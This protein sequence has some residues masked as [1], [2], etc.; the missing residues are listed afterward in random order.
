[1]LT[2]AIFENINF[3]K[4]IVM[5]KTDG[6]RCVIKLTPSTYEIYTESGCENYICET[7][8]DR[9]YV[10]DGEFIGAK[11][12]IFDLLIVDVE[13]AV[14][15]FM[16]R[17]MQLEKIPLPKN[18]M[19]KPVNM[20]TPQNIRRIYYTKHE[21]EIDGLIFNEV[22][23][24]YKYAKIY[25]WKPAELTTIDFLIVPFPYK[26]IKPYISDKNMYILMCGC[27]KSKIRQIGNGNFM[28]YYKRLLIEN[29]LSEH[30]EYVPVPFSPPL[31]KLAYIYESDEVLP[32]CVGEF[33][34]KQNGTNIWDLV[35]IR[36]DKTL[37]IKSGAFGNNYF[38]AET[39]FNELQNR[40]SQ[41]AVVILKK[42]NLKNIVK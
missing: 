25:K 34:L 15:D 14:G 19:L 36:H 38:V 1:L 41:L 13:V 35:K 40:I 32:L 29:N 30:K 31:N 33:A 9:V 23:A 20:A 26:G 27:E 5:D 21:Y 11:Y 2:R 24:S 39:H 3:K 8:V 4:Y 16:E 17:R 42:I 28:T 18:M 6:I 12:V 10:F 37:L 22:E 7:A